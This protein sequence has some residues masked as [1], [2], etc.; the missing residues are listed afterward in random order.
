LKVLLLLWVCKYVT[1]FGNV[2]SPEYFAVAKWIVDAWNQL[3]VNLIK[4]SWNTCGICAMSFADY[5]QHLQ[6][7]LK[8]HIIPPP[9]T[10]EIMT[11][12]EITYTTYSG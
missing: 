7:L 4:K 12:E 2:A 11:P 8:H 6:N 1:C 10:V 9:A 3:D 5:N